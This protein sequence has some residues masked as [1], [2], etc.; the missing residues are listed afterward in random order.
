MSRFPLREIHARGAG[1]IRRRAIF[2]VVAGLA[3]LALGNGC[4]KKPALPELTD[5]NVSP[6]Q[7]ELIARGK[8]VYKTQCIACHNADPA[9]P[10]SLGPEVQGSSRELLE[11][12]ILRAEYPH[13]YQPKRGTHAM[14]AMPHLKSELDALHAFLN[15]R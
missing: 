12:R 3:L 8:T 1:T 15:S 6:A 14:A 9:K 10:G 13:G 11:A 5:A 4:E 7:A 2:S